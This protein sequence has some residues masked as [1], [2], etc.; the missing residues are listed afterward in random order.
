MSGT[1]QFE[2]CNNF[3][4]LNDH[5]IYRAGGVSLV[6]ASYISKYVQRVHRYKSRFI[7]IDLY[8]PAKKIKVINVYCYQ[9][10]DYLTKGKTFVKFPVQKCVFLN[11][12]EIIMNITEKIK[13]IKK[14]IIQYDYSK[15]LIIVKKIY[16]NCKIN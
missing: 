8:L 3:Q 9:S 2:D 5:C 14:I 13:L 15:I 16:W 1:I 6:I 7:N 4:N 12:P 11:K 10:S